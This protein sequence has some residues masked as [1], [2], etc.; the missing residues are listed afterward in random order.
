MLVRLYHVPTCSNCLVP[1]SINGSDAVYSTEVLVNKS[2]ILHCP[3]SGYPTPEIV[4]YHN[5]EIVIPDNSSGIYIMDN[6]WQL[7]IPE[8]QVGHQ[9]QYSCVAK[10]IAG[11]SEKLYSVDVLCEFLCFFLPQ[12]VFHMLI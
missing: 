8:A 9:G 2:A 3:A 11:E 12:F 7:H 10:N 6:G 5:N 1:A 4:W